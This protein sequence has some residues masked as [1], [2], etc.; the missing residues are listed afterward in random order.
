MRPCFR[1]VIRLPKNKNGSCLK[2]FVYLWRVTF[3]LNMKVYFLQFLCN[4]H[5]DLRGTTL[6]F[7]TFKKILQE[8][9]KWRSFQV[10]GSAAAFTSVTNSGINLFKIS[11]KGFAT[12]KFYNPKHLIVKKNVIVQSITSHQQLLQ[13]FLACC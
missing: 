11:F 13:C 7:R 10:S 9:P 5:S 2:F 4:Y 8:M 12:L 1:E 6:Q 3:A